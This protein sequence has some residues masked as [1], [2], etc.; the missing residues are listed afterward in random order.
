MFVPSTSTMAL[1]KW[2]LGLTAG[3]GSASYSAGLAITAIAPHKQ[4]TA[5]EAANSPG[6]SYGDASIDF[7]LINDVV[8][9][10]I[11]PAVNAST[12]SHGTDI[13]GN[14]KIFYT[15]IIDHGS[16]VGDGTVDASR[17]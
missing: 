16:L 11:D 5:A 7:D 9:Q 15:L 2:A 17:T 13:R 14:L 3:Y 8:Y 12:H 1:V 4:S 10:H 6:E